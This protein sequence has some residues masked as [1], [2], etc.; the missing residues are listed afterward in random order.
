MKSFKIR[1]SIIVALLSVI[2]T[3]SCRRS[4]ELAP[5]DADVLAPISYGELDL[6]EILV[7]DELMADSSGL[8]HLRVSDTL[9]NLGLDSLIG[10]PDTSFKEE[11]LIPI[12]NLTLPTGIPF[13]SNTTATKYNLKEVE[14]TYAEVRT[15]LFNVEFTNALK[16]QIIVRY[17]VLSATFDG[18]TFELLEFVPA[19]STFRGDFSLDGYALD[20]RGLNGTAVNTLVS[21]VEVMVDPAEG[22]TYTFSAGE[23]FGIETAFEKIIP[24]YAVGFFG[25]SKTVIEGSTALDVFDEIPFDALDIA[26][27]DVL[28]IIDNGIGADLQLSIDEMSSSNSFGQS[29]TLTHSVIGQTQQLSRAV[30]LFSQQNPVKHIVKT[31]VFNEANSN[32]DELIGLRPSSLNY[33]LDLI[34]NPLGNISLGN[35]FIYYGHDISVL[36]D[37]DVP[38]KVGVLGLVLQDT[39]AV[40]FIEENP[41]QGSGLINGGY[42]RVHFDNAYPFSMEVQLYLQD[43]NGVEIDSLLDEAQ[44]IESSITNEQGELV[45]NGTTEVVIPV[46]QEIIEKL[47]LT[48]ALRMRAVIDTYNGQVVNIYD[49]YRISFKMIADLNVNTQ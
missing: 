31:F 26:E 15:S 37:I 8:F 47:K 5:W 19:K 1:F 45:S 27:F 4:N 42:L 22:A 44:A 6:G 3:N 14:L 41:D 30:N 21:K 46:D 9:I 34:I 33:N 12:G 24:G 23:R 2:L 16:S 35:D 7:S 49:N 13:Y 43:E 11:Y 39:F 17:Q 40:E 29:A 28:M 32:L 25:S 38:L 36:M 20:L 48:R 10:I 18:D